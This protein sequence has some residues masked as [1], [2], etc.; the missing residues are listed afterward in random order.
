[1]RKVHTLLKV[2]TTLNISEKNERY[3][4][5]LEQKRDDCFVSQSSQIYR[6]IVCYSATTEPGGLGAIIVLIF[7]VENTKLS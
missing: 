7:S 5:L 3:I 4:Y 2:I 1:M 6:Q